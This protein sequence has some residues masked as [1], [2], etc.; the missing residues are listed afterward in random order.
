MGAAP[1]IRRI[2]EIDRRAKRLKRRHQSVYDRWARINKERMDLAYELRLLEEE[3]DTLNQGQ[4]IMPMPAV[5]PLL[6][7]GDDSSST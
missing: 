3:R 4:L 5:E 2:R 6:G 1:E 7:P